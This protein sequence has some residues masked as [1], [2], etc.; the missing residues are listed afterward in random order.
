MTETRCECFIPILERYKLRYTIIAVAVAASVSEAHT[1]SM[2][3]QSRPAPQD[4]AG[5]LQRRSDDH[6]NT[7]LCERIAE[8]RLKIIVVLIIMSTNSSPGHHH[9]LSCLIM[10]RRHFGSSCF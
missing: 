4:R 1:K 6:L 10:R 3:P 8:E 5:A 7:A 9:E 2:W